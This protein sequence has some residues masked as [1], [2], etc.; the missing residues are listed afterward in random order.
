MTKAIQ[1]W[2]SERLIW[3]HDPGLHWYN[4]RWI[5][6]SLHEYC[7]IILYSILD[8]SL[9]L[10]CHTHFVVSSDQLTWCNLLLQIDKLNEKYCRYW[11]NGFLRSHMI[12]IYTVCL[13]E[14]GGQ[15]FKILNILVN[16]YFNTPF[17]RKLN[18]CTF[19]ALYITMYMY[20][21][22]NIHIHISVINN[23]VFSL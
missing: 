3:L 10:I 1:T 9:L 13:L 14:S 12:Q 15:G 20:L 8:P 18:L 7:M 22:Y 21:V 17:I 23:C 2:N 16:K 4:I 5:S 6:V 19:L 11:S